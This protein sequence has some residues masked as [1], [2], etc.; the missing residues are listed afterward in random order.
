MNNLF[1]KL[2]KLDILM[3]DEKLDECR[4]KLNYNTLYTLVKN[5]I[6]SFREKIKNREIEDFQVEDIIK[7]ILDRSK[8]AGNNK[9]KKVI[10]GSGVIIHT[11]LGRSVLNKKIVEKMGEVVSNYNN[12]EYDLETGKRGHRNSHVEELICK[13]T[14]AE[15]ALVVNNNA[16]AVI[17]CL[18]EFARGK[19]SIVSR[20]ELVEIGGS[21][22]IPD[23]MELSGSKLK[24]VGTTNK[25]NISDYERAIDEETAL[26]LKVHRSNFKI[27]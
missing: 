14:G 20:G 10:N 25:T 3:K 6:D 8:F 15:G 17:I 9:L 2:P 11:N 27:T 4:K 1:R 23:I 24:E 26:I 22:R 12:L 16:A 5:E 7:N 19:N 21:F 13:I 18:N